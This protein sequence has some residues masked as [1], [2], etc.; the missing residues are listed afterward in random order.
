MTF[1]NIYKYDREKIDSLTYWILVMSYL[2]YKTEYEGAS[3]LKYDSN[4]KQLVEMIK[5]K[6]A[7]KRSLYYYVTK[8]FDG[9]TGFDLFDRLN[10]E[11]KK[12]VVRSAK[13]VK[14]KGWYCL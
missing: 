5:D 11:H 10:K 9:T 12:L 7:H 13:I 2:Y 4:C 6:K 8:D 14:S 1:D 3:N